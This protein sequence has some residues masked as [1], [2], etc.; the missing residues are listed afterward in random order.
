MGVTRARRHTRGSIVESSIVKL[1]LGALVVTV[2][3]LVFAR[4]IYPFIKQ[5][6]GFLP[7]ECASTGRST[8]DYSDLMQAAIK[9]ERIQEVE[10]LYKEFTECSLNEKIDDDI[11]FTIGKKVYEHHLKIYMYK[12]A[13]WILSAYLHQPQRPSHHAEAEK[14]IKE[15]DALYKA[16]PAGQL[17]SLALLEVKDWQQAKN[18]YQRLIEDLST[19]SIDYKNAFSS[20][21]QTAQKKYLNIEADQFRSRNLQPNLPL[22]LLEPTSGAIRYTVRFQGAS[23]QDSLSSYSLSIVAP[24]RS[25]ALPLEPLTFELQR[26]G[27][28]LST[29]REPYTFENSANIVTARALLDRISAFYCPLPNPPAPCAPAPIQTG[30]GA[31]AGDTFLPQPPS[32]PITG[33]VVS[34]STSPHLPFSISPNPPSSST[35]MGLEIPSFEAHAQGKKYAMIV[36]YTP[37]PTPT[38]SILWKDEFEKAVPDVPSPSYLSSLALTSQAL[39]TLCPAYHPP[40]PLTRDM[41]RELVRCLAARQIFLTPYPIPLAP[42]PQN[43]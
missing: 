9:E 1:I 23:P 13:Q 14:L 26:D 16:S 28:A 12:K 33:P 4:P 40:P 27:V 5:A 6:L 19:R 21:M 24:K 25:V 42:L 7:A 22:P 43:H 10:R 30:F 11:H 41:S 29:S 8:Q 36:D 20:E 37:Y 32:T 31:P 3:A 39:R 2:F 35:N 15:A 17:D 18:G 34:F 38:L